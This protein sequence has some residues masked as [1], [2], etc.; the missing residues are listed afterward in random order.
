MAGIIANMK[1]ARAIRKY[2]EFIGAMDMVEEAFA[3][4]LKVID[5]VDDSAEHTGFT[6]PTQDELKGLHRKAFAALD[7]VRVAAKKHEGDLVSREWGL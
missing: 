2:G 6:V 1:N 5:R 3:T 4:V 7:A